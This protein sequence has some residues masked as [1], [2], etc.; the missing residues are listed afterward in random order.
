MRGAVERA[1]RIDVAPVEREPRVVADAALERD[2]ERLELLRRDL[3]VD[4]RVELLPQIRIVVIGHP[5]LV[6]LDARVRDRRALANP[7]VVGEAAHYGA[8][9]AL[10]GS[11]ACD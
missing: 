9:A 11:V 7:G 4:L 8:T 3:D 10:R 2:R 6:D 1:E 5:G